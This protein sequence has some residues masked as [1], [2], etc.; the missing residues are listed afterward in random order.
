MKKNQLDQGVMKRTADLPVCPPPV[1]GFADR[2]VDGFV[3]PYH[4]HDR[5]QLSLFLGGTVTVSALDQSFVLGAGQGLWLPA[6]TLHQAE[7]R[8]NL[9][10]Q[11]VYVD[12]GMSETAD[13]PCKMFAVSSLM[14]GLVDEIIAMQYEFVMDER[15]T[16]IAQ[17]LIDEIRRA[18]PIMNRLIFPSDQRL[19][20]VCMAIVAHPE[21]AGTSTTG[22]VKRVWPDGPLQ[23]SSIRKWVWVLLH[24]VVVSG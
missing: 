3:D 16:A 10:F 20:R 19:L 7:C 21:T 5:A 4:R 14:R 11:V 12:P 1:V 13:L 23:D 2:Y 6:N 24:G 9:T 22:H 18:A 8:T 17:L 15:M